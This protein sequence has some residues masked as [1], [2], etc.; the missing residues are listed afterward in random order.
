MALRASVIRAP[1][2]RALFGFRVEVPPLALAVVLGTIVFDVVLF[3][4]I[5]RRGR[6]LESSALEADSYHFGTDAV[7]KVGV[8]VGIGAAYRGFPA[9]DLVG[10]GAMATAF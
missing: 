1:A 7:G 6:A 9:L 4:Y 3:R 2:R 5:A 10:A 8:L